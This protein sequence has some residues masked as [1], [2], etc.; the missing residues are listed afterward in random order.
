MTNSRKNCF[1]LPKIDEKSLES[2][3]LRPNSLDFLQQQIPEL[4]ESLES[5]CKDFSQLDLSSAAKKFRRIANNLKMLESLCSTEGKCHPKNILNDLTGKQWLRH[6][7]SWL[8]VDGKPGEISPEIKNHPASFP[9]SLAAYFIEYFSKKGQWVFD[10]FMGIGSTAEACFL[11]QRNCFGTEIN[12]DYAQ[13]AQERIIQLQSK[14]SMNNSANS[15]SLS[16][17]SLSFQTLHSNEFDKFKIFHGDAR[18]AVKIWK[19][20]KIPAIDFLITSPPYW[21]ILHTKRGGVKSVLKRRVEAGLDEV[22]SDLDGD[23]GNINEYNKYLGQIKEI[24]SSFRLI[25]KPKAY[26]MVIIQNV[27]PKDGIMVPLAWD[28]AAQLKEDYLL[29]QE[30]IWCQDQKFLGIWGYPSTYVSNVH[31]HYCLVFQKN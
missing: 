24:F 22:Y 8:I 11:T 20:S 17:G 29:R 5:G 6:T 23:L 12:L 28:I 13:Y 21:N 7:K 3:N 15:D 31:H 26:V 27:R 9:P 18:T 1:F 30:F 10:P 25:L 19:D 4:Q 14:T 2:H 16:P